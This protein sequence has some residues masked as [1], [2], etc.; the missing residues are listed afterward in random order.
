[1]I[2]LAAMVAPAGLITLLLTM[3]FGA[4]RS[5][6]LVVAAIDGMG[7]AALGLAAGVT[8]RLAGSVVRR[9]RAALA[10]GA[11]FLG[12]GAVAWI[13]PEI[14]LLIIAGGAVVGTLFLGSTPAMPTAPVAPEAA[15]TV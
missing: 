1:V 10:D 8:A 15:E 2:G 14:P 7:P 9:G 6:P 4:I 3:G 12:A 13:N 5:D 11:L